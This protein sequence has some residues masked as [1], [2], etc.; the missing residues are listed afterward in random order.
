MGVLALQGGT[1]VGQ[2]GRRMRVLILWVFQFRKLQ[3]PRLPLYS[4]ETERHAFAHGSRGSLVQAAALG[5]VNTEG[6]QVRVDLLKRTMDRRRRQQRRGV[7]VQCWTLMFLASWTLTR[8]WLTL[9]PSSSRPQTP[10]CGVVRPF[11][12]D[13]QNAARDMCSIQ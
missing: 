10:D 1:R 8:T 5:T 3:I 7:N 13:G 9:G 6:T 12:I 11:R 2:G 4:R